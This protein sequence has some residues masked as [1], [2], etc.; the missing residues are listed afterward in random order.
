[1]VQM[2][3]GDQNRIER[4]IEIGAPCEERLQKREQ[5]RLVLVVLSARV[6]EHRSTREFQQR[7]VCLPDVDEVRRHRH[8]G[9]TRGRGSDEDGKERSRHKVSTHQTPQ[10]I[11]GAAVRTVPR[12][13]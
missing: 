12:H 13:S 7:R 6:D 2:V 8:L 3:V 4:A 10:F 9:L 11:S 1:M 5:F